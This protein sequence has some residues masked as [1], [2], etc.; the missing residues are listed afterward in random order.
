MRLTTHHIAI[1]CEVGALLLGLLG[2]DLLAE[3]KL[4]A[5]DP[6]VVVLLE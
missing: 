6:G 4:P 5:G 2:M 1:L 3:T